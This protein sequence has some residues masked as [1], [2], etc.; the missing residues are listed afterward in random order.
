M[1][2]EYINVIKEYASKLPEA[3]KGRLADANEKKEL[4]KYVGEISDE[5]WW[6]LQEIGNC[7]IGP[8][9]IDGIDEV[10]ASNKKF[11]NEADF[12]RMNNVV[13]VGWDGSGNP[14]GQ[15]VNTGKI[16]IEYHDG[17]D[18]VFELA[19]CFA[20]FLIKLINGK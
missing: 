16:M 17:P 5:H 8:D 10:M 13:I 3:L 14:F 18:G 11:K 1:N 12:W 9:W 2:T 19:P 6:F 7:P 4:E 20:A 15:K